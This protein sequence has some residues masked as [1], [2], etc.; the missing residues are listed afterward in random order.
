MKKAKLRKFADG[1]KLY[2]VCPNCNHHIVI[3]ICPCCEKE[4]EMQD[5]PLDDYQGDNFPT[6][7]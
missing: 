3:S 7:P 6:I 5:F 1:D 2:I 4:F